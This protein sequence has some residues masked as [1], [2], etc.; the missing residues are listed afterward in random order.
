MH[1]QQDPPETF[2]TQIKLA[3]SRS[4][5]T[6][7]EIATQQL[8]GFVNTSTSSRFPLDM[9]RAW[10]RVTGSRGILDLLPERI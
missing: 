1:I 5:L 6:G 4:G 10:G 9:L 2:I 8:E 3:A 7:R